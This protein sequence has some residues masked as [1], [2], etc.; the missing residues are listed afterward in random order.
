[1]PNQLPCIL[2]HLKV[3]EDKYMLR[4]CA[5]LKDTK[6]TQHLNA[7]WD[8]KLDCELGKYTWSE[9][10]W[11]NSEIWLSTVDSRRIQYQL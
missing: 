11:E 2:Q 4:K 9:H 3:M 5:R 6:D 8:S 10:Y 1:M 7:M